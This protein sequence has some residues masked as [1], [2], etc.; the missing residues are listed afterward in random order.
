M[1]KKAHSISAKRPRAKAADA[2]SLID[3]E[4]PESSQHVLD[5]RARA[6]DFGLI[7]V[8]QADT[9][10]MPLVQPADQL[11]HEEE[12][13]AFEEQPVEAHRAAQPFDEEEEDT[14]EVA[15]ETTVVSEDIDLVRVYLRHIGK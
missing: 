2:P 12:P 13:E 8:D 14:P 10:E 6:H 11:L 7:P 1:A 15:P 4:N 5:W 3:W 9:S